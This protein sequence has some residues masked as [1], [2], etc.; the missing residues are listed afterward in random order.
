MKNAKGVIVGTDRAMEWLL[1]WWWKYYSLHNDFPV[2]FIDFGMSQKALRFCKERGLVIPCAMAGLKT[3]SEEIFKEEKGW[4]V[5]N[6]RDWRG[7]VFKKP[8]AMSFSPYD[9]TVWMDLD[10]EVCSSILPLFCLLS[11]E[12][13]FAITKHEGGQGIYCNSGVVVFKKGSSTLEA[14]KSFCLLEAQK[15]FADDVALTHL[16]VSK[17]VSITELPLK[18]NWL[19]HYGPNPFA[20]ICHWACEPGKEFIKKHEGFQ[21]FKP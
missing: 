17:K 3:Y 13:D 15:F 14:W 16:I 18:W 8:F 2:T 9:T 11:P 1:P 7:V 4:P 21:A 6:I 20:L 12:S 10:C 19:M 5:D